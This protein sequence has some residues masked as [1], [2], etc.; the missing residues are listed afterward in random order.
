[1]STATPCTASCSTTCW[2]ADCCLLRPCGSCVRAAAHTALCCTRASTARE[3]Q[4]GGGRRSRDGRAAT[5]WSTCCASEECWSRI[6]PTPSSASTR[7]NSCRCP[8][9]AIAATTIWCCSMSR[10]VRR[11]RS[12]SG[13]P[14]SRRLIAS[15]RTRCSTRMKCLIGAR[16]VSVV[17]MPMSLSVS[18]VVHRYRDRALSCS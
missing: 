10:L 9:R 13:S 15:S 11:S 18:A 3:R 7:S 17:G 5:A 14:R 4:V 12:A 8:A 16:N 6:S 1:M 2:Y